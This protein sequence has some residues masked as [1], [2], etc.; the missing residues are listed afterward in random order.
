MPTDV[1]KK[2]DA[3]VV[4]HAVET[5][6]DAGDRQRAIDLLREEDALDAND[7][8][9]MRRIAGLYFEL[10]LPADALT[11]YRRILE[12][13]PDDPGSHYDVGISLYHC[14]DVAASRG[15]FED[16]VRLDPDYADAQLMLGHVLLELG[17]FAAGWQKFR[18]RRALDPDLELPDLPE[19]R[20][21][22]FDGKDLLVFQEGGHGDSMWASRFLP[23]VKA[24]GGNVYLVTRQSTRRL[25][26]TLEGVDGYA[27]EGFDEAEFD[28]F[29]TLLDLPAAL[30]LTDPL[31]VPLPTFYAAEPRK[32]QRA[33][34]AR[35]P[36]KTFKVGIVWS[37]SEGY[38]EN[39]RRSVSLDRFLRLAD[40][41]GIQLFSLQKGPQQDVLKE[42]KL[43]DRII[44]LDDGD[45]AETSG[46]IRA[47]DLIIMTDTAIAHLAGS[48]DCPVW[49]LLSHR[50]YW[51]FG[52]E[53]ERS[54]WY[55]SMRLFRQPDP[56]DWNNVFQD[57]ERALRE[58]VQERFSEGTP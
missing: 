5:A 9:R 11:V 35:A 7:V 48:I 57:V 25:F 14:N 55:P 21:E 10:D 26:A 4:L 3:A 39:A 19:W 18:W 46:L 16:A 45:F 8:E 29:T 53:G 41:P 54:P 33:L 12:C 2:I 13:K 24:R 37:G 27:D 1:P 32:G 38:A 58:I 50:P 34:F 17:D 30:G 36:E 52:S 43:G 15:P 56:G 49:V 23:A 51:F 47:L 6:I 20:G 40:V 22:R 42:A 44:D 28:L 31:S